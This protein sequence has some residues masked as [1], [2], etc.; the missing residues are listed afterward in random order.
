MSTP[1]HIRVCWVLKTK[2][3]HIYIV[4]NSGGG[5]S[6]I[7]RRRDEKKG[8]TPSKTNQFW[9]I[10]TYCLW[11]SLLLFFIFPSFSLFFSPIFRLARNFRVGGGEC[12]PLKILG[13]D[14]SPQSP[15]PPLPPPVVVNGT[16]YQQIVLA[17]EAKNVVS[18]PLSRCSKTKQS[19]KIR[20]IKGGK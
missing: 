8:V 17:L 10:C 19:D 11:A 16:L 14:T 5:R 6:T 15:P 13:W 1:K 18:V 4:V 3:Q 9:S 12:P 2:R 20:H 7:L